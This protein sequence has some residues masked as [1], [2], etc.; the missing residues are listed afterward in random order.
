MALDGGNVDQVE[1]STPLLRSPNPNAGNLAFR[2]DAVTADAV[3]SRVLSGLHLQP[4]RSVVDSF[5]DLPP[6]VQ[7]EAQNQNHH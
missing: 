4:K 5:F 7:A 2:V 3:L 1:K 6:E